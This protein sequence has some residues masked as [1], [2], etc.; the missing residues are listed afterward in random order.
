MAEL[1]GVDTTRVTS[2]CILISS[3]LAAVAGWMLTAAEG[4]LTADSAV[5]A[6]IYMSFAALLG[7]LGSL[8]GSA[9]G[10]LVVGIGQAFWSAWF[11]QSYAA[12]AI[13]AGVIFAV[14]FLP[15]ATAQRSLIKEL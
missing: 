7:G 8:K 13:F 14:R 12:L 6:V 4:P 9:A 1:L 10:G 15:E 3:M 2:L 11:G 5:L